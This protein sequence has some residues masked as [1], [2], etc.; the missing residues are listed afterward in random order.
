MAG[1]LGYTCGMTE[2]PIIRKSSSA[3]VLFKLLL[4]LAALA[5]ALSTVEFAQVMTLL[6]APAPDVVLVAAGLLLLQ[7]AIGALRWHWL[8]RLMQ[9]GAG[10]ILRFGRMLKLFYIGVF[11]NCCLPGT[12]GGDAVRVWLLTRAGQAFSPSLGAVVVDRLLALCGLG[13]L[14][15]A[16]AWLVWGAVLSPLWM[17]AS[18]AAAILLIAVGVCLTVRLDMFLVRIPFLTNVGWVQHLARSIAHTRAHPAQWG[19]SLLLALL[20]HACYAAAGWWLLRGMGVEVPLLPWVG[21]MAWV[22]LV[23]LLP[24]SLGGW[25]VRE[26]AMISFMA[27]LGV[28]E[29]MAMAVSVQLGVLYTLLSLPAGGL[30]LLMKDGKP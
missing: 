24:L 20:G 15:V 7:V 25:G 19:V 17:W 16:G 12:I 21:L 14:G 30:W 8:V 26:V 23:S 1:L 22:I 4:T 9:Q 10:P 3:H 11:F 27:A 2:L 18:A 13:V 29:S 5:F 6:T 28:E